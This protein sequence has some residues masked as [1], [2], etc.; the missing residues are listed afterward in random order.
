MHGFL[1]LLIILVGLLF[2]AIAWGIK[3]ALS[4]KPSDDR[5]EMRDDVLLIVL[6]IAA[7]TSGVFLAII[8]FGLGV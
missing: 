4:K 8:S 1:F 2:G 5:I 6:V 7:L 3:Q